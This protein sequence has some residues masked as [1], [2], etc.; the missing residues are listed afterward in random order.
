M[1]SVST[2]LAK[3]SWADCRLVRAYDSGG[4]NDNEWLNVNVSSLSSVS[5][6]IIRVQ[7]AE[8]CK[9]CLMYA[10]ERAPRLTNSIAEY[11]R[12]LHFL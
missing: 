10:K 1:G 3:S 2:L 11:S 5:D 4:A 12:R 8:R 7:S 9:M 6:R